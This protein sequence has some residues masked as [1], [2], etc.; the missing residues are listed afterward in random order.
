M[1]QP[2]GNFN[3]S[4]T[5]LYL[6]FRFSILAEILK[7]SVPKS[8]N[9]NE[10]LKSDLIEDIS[11][12]QGS[13][14]RLVSVPKFQK[15]SILKSLP[16]PDFRIL[17]LIKSLEHVPMFKDQLHSRLDAQSKGQLSFLLQ[18]FNTSI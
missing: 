2:Y 14:N 9:S 17:Q 16:D 10:L 5:T 6:C 13:F 11:A 18:K 7:V 3:I 4:H 12:T 15:Y 8:S 1:A